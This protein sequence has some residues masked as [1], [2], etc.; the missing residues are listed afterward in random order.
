MKQLE[1]LN[2]SYN[3]IGHGIEEVLAKSFGL[4]QDRLESLKLVQ[5]DL[6]DEYVKYIYDGLKKAPN[7]LDIDL[8]HNDFV[9]TYP[10]IMFAIRD[11]CEM[12]QQVA[13]SHC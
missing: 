7:L 1:Y 3:K 4:V 2:L 10:D 12:I 8:S 13:L 11:N 6:K 5:C 9:D